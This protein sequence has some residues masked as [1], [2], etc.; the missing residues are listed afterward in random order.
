MPD[1]LQEARWPADNDENIL[2]FR[3]EEMTEFLLN[4][5]KGCATFGCFSGDPMTK[6]RD[7]DGQPHGYDE[8]YLPSPMAYYRWPWRNFQPE[9]DRFDWIVMDQALETAHQHGQ[10]LEIRLM[11]HTH[12]EEG[13]RC[14]TGT[15]IATPPSQAPTSR[16]PT[17]RRSTT[18]RT[19]WSIGAT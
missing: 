11:P 8:Y 17:P 4:P 14:R 6:W 5:H 15:R 13:A 1:L 7:K 18:G 12:A 10:A 9:P 19:T 16:I 2:R 3:P